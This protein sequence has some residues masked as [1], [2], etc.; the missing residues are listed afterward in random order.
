[1]DGVMF[2]HSRRMDRIREVLNDGQSIGQVTR[3]A[4][5]APLDPHAPP[6]ARVRADDD[7]LSAFAERTRLGP[8]TR[9]R[10]LEAAS[11]S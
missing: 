5:D 7:A 4:C 10:L 1:M 9:R 3:I 2:M 8:M 6:F 11:I